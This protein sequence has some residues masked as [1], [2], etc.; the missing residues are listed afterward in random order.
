MLFLKEFFFSQWQG[1]Y[2][3]MKKRRDYC[4]EAIDILQKAIG[5]ANAEK[6][7][8]EKSKMIRC[9]TFSFLL[10]LFVEI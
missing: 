4:K 8:V 6:A 5:V 1:K 3:G 7:N 9:S 2:I 10:K